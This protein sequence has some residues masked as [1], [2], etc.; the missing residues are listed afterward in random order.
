MPARE[1]AYARIDARDAPIIEIIED[2]ERVLM[3]NGQ[4]HLWHRCGI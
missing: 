1:W 4:R 3:A 2:D